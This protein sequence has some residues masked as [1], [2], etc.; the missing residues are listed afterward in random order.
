MDTIDFA[1]RE[2]KRRSLA[3]VAE[4]LS[5]HRTASSAAAP[6]APPDDDDDADVKRGKGKPQMTRHASMAAIPVQIPPRR[7]KDKN[8]KRYITVTF[9]RRGWQRALGSARTCERTFGIDAYGQVVY[10]ACDGKA[11]VESII[12]RFA[13]SHHLSIPE[14]E[15]AVTTF[16]KVLTSKGLLAMTLEEE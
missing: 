1:L 6:L 9:E 14:A 7:V 4:A 13:N 12:R 15:T 11:C 10:D 3:K 5:T 8:K 16:M 2:M